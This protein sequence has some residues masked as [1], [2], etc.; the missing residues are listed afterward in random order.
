MDKIIRKFLPQFVKM[1]PDFSK[2]TKRI[3]LFENKEMSVVGFHWKKAQTLPL[4][5]HYGKCSF[6]VIDGKLLEKREIMTR[7][8]RTGDVGKIDKGIKHEI[9]PLENSQSIHVYSPPP[10]KKID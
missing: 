3:V 6:Q 8:L 7:V 10:P 1:K 9:L 2:E 4:H 5:D